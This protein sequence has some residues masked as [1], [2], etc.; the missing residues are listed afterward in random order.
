MNRVTKAT[1]ISA[2]ITI[3]IQ[4]HTNLAARF[5]FFLMSANEKP[6]KPALSGN[7][8]FRFADKI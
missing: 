7:D 6:N 8:W 4:R 1:K 5:T 3:T 2:T